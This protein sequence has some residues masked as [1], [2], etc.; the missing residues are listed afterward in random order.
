MA[1]ILG[2]IAKGQG[3]QGWSEDQWNELRATYYG[4][5]MRVDDQFGQVLQALRDAN[6]V[7]FLADHGDFAGDYGLVEK[8]QNTFQDCLTRVPL[9][10]KP[11]SWLPLARPKGTD[12]KPNVISNTMVELIDFTETVYAMTNVVPDYDRFGHSLLPLITGQ[13]TTNRDA[14]HCE[15]GRRAKERQAMELQSGGSSDTPGGAEP[16]GIGARVYAPRAS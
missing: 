9:V 15:G 1:P 16:H 6:L 12:N 5:C 4:M 11:P 7:F 13:K 8:N 2:C 14:V 3:L 10:I